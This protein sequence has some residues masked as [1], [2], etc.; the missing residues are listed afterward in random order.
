[1]QIT[2]PRYIVQGKSLF[3]AG[4]IM[5]QLFEVA[6]T[7]DQPDMC[8]IAPTFR[9]VAKANVTPPPRSTPNCSISVQIT[10]RS[11]PA[12]VYAPVIAGQHRDAC[13]DIDVQQGVDRQAPKVKHGGDLDKDILQQHQPSVGHAGRRAEPLLQELR[14]RVE[15]VAEV[16]RQEDPEQGVE[17]DQNGPPLDDDRREATE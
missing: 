7:A 16:K 11:P 6:N 10:A 13:H 15:A 9:I 1:M 12:I 4:R 5:C 8:W 3:V 17:P 2:P 14:H